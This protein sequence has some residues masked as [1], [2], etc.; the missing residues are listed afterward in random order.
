VP[1]D[2]ELLIDGNKAPFIDHDILETIG[3]FGG[4]AGSQHQGRLQD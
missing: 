2:S 1:N 4:G 3:D